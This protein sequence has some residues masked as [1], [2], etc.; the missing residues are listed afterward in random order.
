MPRPGSVVVPVE[1]DDKTK[2][3]IA[4]AKRNF[5]SLGTAASKNLDTVAGKAQGV[6]GVLGGIGQDIKGSLIAPLAG[7]A[8]AGAVIGGLTASFR[9]LVDQTREVSRQAERYN[10]EAERI[11]GQARH[12]RILGHETR[13]LSDLYETLV[14][15][16]GELNKGEALA[17]EHFTNLGLA[18]EDFI[19]LDVAGQVT[20]MSEALRDMEDTTKRSTE[21]YALLGGDA[22]ALLDIAAQAPDEFRKWQT[23]MG[24]V[25]DSILEQERL[26]RE[27]RE[28][29]M[30]LFSTVVTGWAD[31]AGDWLNPVPRELRNR[32]RSLAAA[33]AAPDE[34]FR[35]LARPD[36][37]G[38]NPNAPNTYLAGID[39]LLDDGG[40]QYGKAV[41]DTLNASAQAWVDRQHE[42]REAADA[43]AASVG[44]LAGEVS[45]VSNTQLAGLLG[46]LSKMGGELGILSSSVL[47]QVEAQQELAEVEQARAVLAQAAAQAMA[48]GNDSMAASLTQ[49]LSLLENARSLNAQAAASVDVEALN[50]DSGH[51]RYIRRSDD[52]VIVRGHGTADAFRRSRQPG[53]DVDQDPY[54]GVSATGW[55]RQS[56]I[57]DLDRSQDYRQE[58]D[59]IESVTQAGVSGLA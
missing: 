17:V 1:A 21:A 45:E 32:L 54:G 14:E 37:G 16:V 35:R 19:G 39:A 59:K 49:M 55:R 11:A 36:L 51:L 13:D 6:R 8:S 46:D 22:K 18:A 57:E 34:D 4:S 27:L 31:F 30:D 48:A 47:E 44:K 12:F 58:R 3:G 2:T 52:S 38:P 28:H 56:Y 9:E 15:R 42:M 5:Q 26:V 33:G 7:L 53:Y 50:R 43:T 20:L 10:A 40:R 29:W 25:N 41:T 24:N 23:E